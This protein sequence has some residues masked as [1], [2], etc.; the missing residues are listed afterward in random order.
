L[1]QHALF[2]RDY[3]STHADGAESCEA[4]RKSSKFLFEER[5]LMDQTPGADKLNWTT[6]TPIAVPPAH[7]EARLAIR[8]LD[9]RRI[10]RSLDACKQR[11]PALSV[12]YSV[13][14]G[15]AGSAGFSIIPIVMASNLPAW[16][17]PFYVIATVFSLLF[18][19]ALWIIEKN[20]YG[21]LESRIDN[22]DADMTEVEQALDQQLAGTSVSKQTHE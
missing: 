9:W 14:F 1:W 22:I 18:G 20:L 8:L 21:H 2:Q 13:S 15:V 10:R 12:W 6:S 3:S 4:G 19:I 11:Q 7:T 17:A 5:L 16:V